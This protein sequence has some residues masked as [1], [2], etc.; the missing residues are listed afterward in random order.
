MVS[1]ITAYFNKLTRLKLYQLIENPIVNYLYYII[2]GSYVLN[3]YLFNITSNYE[4]CSIL[5]FLV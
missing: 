3:F 4:V 1:F 5:P 2:I